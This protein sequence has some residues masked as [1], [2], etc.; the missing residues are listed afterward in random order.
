MDLFTQ[1]PSQQGMSG[2]HRADS[3]TTWQ[4]RIAVGSTLAR[5]FVLAGVGTKYHHKTTVLLVPTQ[6]KYAEVG[7]NLESNEQTY[8]NGEKKNKKL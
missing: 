7:K 2:Q 1:R 5:F 4:R 6:K 3:D 8:K